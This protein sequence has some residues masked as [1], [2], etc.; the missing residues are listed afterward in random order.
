MQVYILLEERDEAV[1]DV[2]VV[3]GVVVDAMLPLK[4]NK[5]T[6]CHSMPVPPV[7]VRRRGRGRP[8]TGRAR[9]GRTFSY[10]YFDILKTVRENCPWYIIDNDIWWMRFILDWKEDAGEDE[11]MRKIAAY[12]MPVNPTPTFPASTFPVANFLVFFLGGGGG[13][14]IVTAPK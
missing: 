2:A 12:R 10:W 14:R 4:Q 11:M 5:K 7:N 1:V 9:G 3:D 6:G 8:P 13:G